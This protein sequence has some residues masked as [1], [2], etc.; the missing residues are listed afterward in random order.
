MACLTVVFFFWL[1]LPFP[2]GSKPTN[3]TDSLWRKLINLNMKKREAE[4]NTEILYDALSSKT[5]FCSDF[6]NIK[7]YLI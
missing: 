6:L 4:K 7:I 1:R 5:R 3:H 2:L